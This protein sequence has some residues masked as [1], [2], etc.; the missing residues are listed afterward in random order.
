VIF[1]HL[2]GVLLDKKMY[3]R[4]LFL[5]SGVYNLIGLVLLGIIPIFVDGFL[6]FFGITNPD[7]LLFVHI[8]VIII[9]SFSIGHFMLFKDISK[10]HALVLVGA[11]GRAATFF[12]VLIYLIL[13]DCNWI[14][15]LLLSF[16][17]ILATLY[18]EFLVNYKKLETET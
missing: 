2:E 6:P 9:A 15:L 17:I 7:S 13:G 14:F 10:N 11:V 1:Y 4:I 18:V 16:D 12:L 5:I 8:F 3:Y